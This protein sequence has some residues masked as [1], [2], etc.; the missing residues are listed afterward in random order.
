MKLLISKSMVP[1][2]V[3]FSLF[4]FSTDVQASGR[5]VSG[6][7][8]TRTPFD[9]KI[10]RAQLQVDTQGST[11]MSNE[12]IEDLFRIAKSFRYK[13]DMYGDVWQS[14]SETDKSRSGDCEDKAIWLFTK[15]SQNGYND[16]RLVV[17]KFRTIDKQFHAWVTVRVDGNDY[18]LDPANQKR[19]WE[20]GQFQSG[21][22]TAYFSF[23]GESKFKHSI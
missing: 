21:F 19:V 2:I 10:V 16:I 6:R 7:L 17:G 11:Q 20:N 9:H 15:L 23:D 3:A 1:I 12:S 18:L 22:Y 5:S 4:L 13:R 14:A 8:T